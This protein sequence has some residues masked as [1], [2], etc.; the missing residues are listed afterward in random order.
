MIS[1]AGLL[2]AETNPTE[3]THQ[4]KQTDEPQKYAMPTN[5]VSSHILDIAAGR[6]AEGVKCTAYKWKVSEQR[7]EKNVTGDEHGEEGGNWEL[8]GQTE[9]NEQGRIAIVHPGKALSEGIFK[10][11]FRTKEYFE[12]QK[13][14][15]FYPFIEIVFQID[16]PTAHYHVPITL[17]NFGY[18]TYKG[19]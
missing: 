1:S 19:Q 7:S 2:N 14:N 8:W 6:P 17:S 4:Q 3:D 13:R 15:T 18:S 5:N 16:D 9:T 12:G 10:L 11:H